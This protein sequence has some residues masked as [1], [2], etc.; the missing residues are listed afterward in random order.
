MD[1]GSVSEK[2]KGRAVSGSP[3]NGRLVDRWLGRLASCPIAHCQGEFWQYGQGLWHARAEGQIRQQLLGVAEESRA[4]GVK[5]TGGLISSMLQ[6]VRDKCD[7]DK[8]AFRPDPNRLVCT[9]GALD[10]KARQL[11]PWS[12][13]HYALH[14]VAYDYD[15]EAKRPGFDRYLADLSLGADVIAFLQEFAGYCLTG[16]TRYERAVWLQGPPGSGKSTLIEGIQAALSDRWCTLGLADIE[17]SQFRLWNLPGKTLAVATEQPSGYLRTE[18][19]LNRL[20]SGE[21]ITIERKH[22]DSYDFSPQVKLL[23]AMNDLPISTDTANGIF[24]RVSIVRFPALKGAADPSLKEQIKGEGAGILN[25]CLDGLERLNQRGRFDL[26]EVVQ[27]ATVQFRDG[28]DVEKAFA[29]ERLKLG[30]DLMIRSRDLYALYA[31]WCRESGHKAKSLTRIAEDWSRLGLRRDRDRLG[32]L[33]WGA[34]EG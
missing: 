23:W 29:D 2:R 8:G 4:E 21:T 25:W 27:E 18:H 3:D 30:P 14:G 13:E 26:P 1:I 16:D 15:P 33:Y 5:V 11:E 32:K 19:L 24:R 12:R 17:R 34:E 28:C 10:L 22:Q 6:L 7:I 31:T 9:N 20:I